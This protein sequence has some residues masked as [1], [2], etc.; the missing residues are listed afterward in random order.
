MKRTPVLLVAMVVFSLTAPAS[1]AVEP[2]EM[3]V[4]QNQ[5]I[6]LYFPNE[7]DLTRKK[8]LTFEA[9]DELVGHQRFA[10]HSL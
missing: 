4:V 2:I 9:A 10:G 3:V 5:P 6:G 1:A 7:F 8:L